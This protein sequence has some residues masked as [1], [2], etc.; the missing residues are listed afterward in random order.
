ML[1]I[2]PAMTWGNIPVEENTGTGPIIQVQS[3]RCGRLLLSYIDALQRSNEKLR[4]ND[5]QLKGIHLQRGFYP[6][7]YKRRKGAADLIKLQSSSDI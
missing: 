4:A 7:Q 2:S 6:L 1:K 3:N 5:N